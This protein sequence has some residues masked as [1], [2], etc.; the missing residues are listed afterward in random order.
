G[1]GNFVVTEVR[2]Q[3]VDTDG[4]PIAKAP[5]FL[6]A[7]ASFE[8]TLFAGDDLRFKRWGAHNT[9]DNDLR[10][11][12]PGWA[13]L[14]EVGRGHH[15]V[16][17]FAEPAPVPAGARLRLTLEQNHSGDHNLGCF[18][19][20]LAQDAPSA[21][22]TPVRP[23]KVSASGDIVLAVRPDLSILASGPNN[24]KGS[25]AI[26]LPVRDRISGVRIDALPDPSLPQGGPGRA[27]NGNFVLTEVKGQVVLADG[28]L[29]RTVR[30]THA[31]A[32]FEQILFAGDDIPGKRWGALHAVDNDATLPYL[33]WAILP[34]TNKPHSI[35]LGLAEPLTLPE[36]AS[37]RLVLENNHSTDH[38]LGC[39]RISTTNVAPA[40]R[41]VPAAELT[42]ADLADI[43]P[44]K[45]TPDQ[46]K[47][48]SDAFAAK[49]PEVAA[50]RDEVA[51]AQAERARI[52]QMLPRCLVTNRNAT[53][54]A[55]RILPRGNFLDETGP[56][57]Q[58]AL[59]GFL[60]KGP[61][62]R[63]SLNRL[64]LADWLVDR[65]NPLVARTVMNR[66]WKQFFGAGLSRVADDLGAQGEPPTHPELLDWLAVEFQDRAWDI[67]AMVRTIVTSRTYMQSS[68]APRALRLRDPENRLLARQGRWR[69][70]AELVRDNALALSGLLVRTIGGPS[71]KPYQPERYW[72]NL[73]FPVRDYLADKG[74]GQYRRG[75]YTWWQRSFLHPS[76]L[77]FDAPSREEC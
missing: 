27:G 9:I 50:L 11:G 17:H 73:N 15:L 58:A 43:E 31:A 65:R 77:A 3:W 38:N 14:P 42:L 6:N 51:G 10:G 46:E 29:G 67:K 76:L 49:A 53:P 4:N 56:L 33:G 30:F 13:I 32:S 8:Q 34:E 48:L 20:S 23:G 26:D 7:E 5:L 57:V 44:A 75:L 2:A 35:V 62:P 40:I 28:T 74:E 69:L 66:L 59:P 71:V 19:V 16:L 36:G 70:D 39:F 61:D 25:Y 12:V 41:A 64:D 18:K 60:P 24:V 21:G 72:E 54:R 37:L 63:R 1:N 47:Q 55:V 22:W 68:V 45:R 52:E